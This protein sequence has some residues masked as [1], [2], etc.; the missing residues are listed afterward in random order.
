MDFG[1]PFPDTPNEGTIKSE[2]E[3]MPIAS[4]DFESGPPGEDA[5]E[6]ARVVDRAIRE[7]QCLDLKSLCITPGE[8]VWSISLDTIILNHDGN[9]IDAATIG[10]MVALLNS[11]IP[12]LEDDK[13]VRDK[14]SGKLPVSSKAVNVTVC[15]FEDKFILDPTREEEE[16]FDTKMCIGVRDDGKVVS[17]Q[18][19]GPGSLKDSEIY[20]MI[21]IAIKKS[22]NLF[23]LVGKDGKKDI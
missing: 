18:K 3:F 20:D 4:E 21:D 1:T 22:K 7:S 15:K 9:L 23:K 11:K 6:L 17:I 13:I 2:A 19:M 8:K 14:H 10:A 12:E 5:I 16:V